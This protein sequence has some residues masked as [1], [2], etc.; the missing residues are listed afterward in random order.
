MAYSTATRSPP[1]RS[2]RRTGSRTTRRSGG[3]RSAPCG[4]SSQAQNAETGG[5]RYNPGQAG[6]TSV[7][8]WQMFA[9]RSA[10]LAG[11]EVPK[12]VLKGCKLYLDSAAADSSKVT[13][14]LH[15]RPAGHARD[16][17]RS[18]AEPAVPRLAPRLP[19]ADQ[20]RQAHRRRPR[21]VGG[22]EHLLL[23]LRDPAA[24][25]HAEQGLEALER[26]GPRRPGRHAGQG[27][28][29]RPRELGPDLAP[30]RPLGPL[31]RAGSSS[32]RSRC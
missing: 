24:P 19:P 5:W 26:A 6:D 11:L 14:L 30:A 3:R 2:A 18:A 23:V 15:A 4:S 28:R 22:A 25:Q 8:G 32:P 9:L 7:F 1:W 27:R 12:N 31:R 29:L 10:R 20:G 16:D 17:R 13:L 21:A